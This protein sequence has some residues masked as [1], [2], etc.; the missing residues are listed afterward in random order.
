RAAPDVPGRRTELGALVDADDAEAVARRVRLR[1]GGVDRRA[2]F[3]AE[4][5]V[6]LVPALGGRDVDSRRPAGKPERLRQARDIGPERGAGQLLAV[7]AMAHAHC[8]RIDLGLVGDVPAMAPA[9]DLHT[10]H[11]PASRAA[12]GANRPD[13]VRGSYSRQIP[14]AR[15]AP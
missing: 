5:V 10:A 2:A 15:A 1:R 13:R 7:R 6:A 12:T 9:G 4:G 14:S 3:R 8:R 11:L